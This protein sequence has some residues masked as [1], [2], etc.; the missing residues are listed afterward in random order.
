MQLEHVV[1]AIITNFI[2]YFG[3]VMLF[4]DTYVTLQC[5]ITCSTLYASIKS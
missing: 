1:N 3:A 5:N 4:T 2:G